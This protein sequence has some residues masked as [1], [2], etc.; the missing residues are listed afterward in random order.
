MVAISHSIVLFIATSLFRLT[1]SGGN[2]DGKI[3]KLDSVFDSLKLWQDANHNGVSESNELHSLKDLGLKSIGVDYKTSKIE[4]E[5]LEGPSSSEGP[6]CMGVCGWG[7]W[8]WPRSR[9]GQSST[10]NFQLRTNVSSF[11]HHQS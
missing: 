1:G 5:E 6:D 10:K 4:F 9:F 8:A 3:N 11:S 2:G 7:R